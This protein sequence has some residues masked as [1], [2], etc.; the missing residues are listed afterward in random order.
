MSIVEKMHFEDTQTTTAASSATGMII[1]QKDPV[2]LE[3]PFDKLDSFLTPND[4][5]YIRSHFEA[6]KLTTDSYQLRIHGAVE[7]PLSLNYQQLREFPSETRTATLECAG[8]SRVFLV[9]Q[10][11]GAQWELGAVGN[12]EWTGVPRRVLLEQAGLA[13]NACEVVFEGADR[14]SPKERPLPPGPISYARS[15]PLEKAG[16][17]EVLVAYQMNGREPSQ[18]HGYPVRLI[19]PGYYGMASVKWL[20]SI[21][22]L[23]EPFQ[24]YWQ[25]SDYGYWDYIDGKPVRRPLSEIVLKS[26]IARPSMYEVI[27][28]GSEYIVTGAAWSGNIDVSD[29]E[30]TTDGGKHWTAGKFIDIA[31]RYVWRRWQF[32]WHV[33]QKP[34]QYTLAARA[35]DTNGAVQPEG[36]DPSHGP[37]IINHPLPIDV[38]VQ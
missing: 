12:A 8:N 27:P 35:K 34:G 15:L 21:Q 2:N 36:H 1:R 30:L 7:N 26:Q 17:P 37:Y 32:V 13:R 16:R 24:G 23:V 19:V 14:G 9:P 33:P 4:L 11:E 25:T 18:D 38:I 28:A 5:F 20:I 6:P 31:Q 22:V 3:F 29:I 10:A